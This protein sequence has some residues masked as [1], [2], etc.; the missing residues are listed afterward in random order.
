MNYSGF[1]SKI[2][3]S[4]MVNCFEKK[5]AGI[6]NKYDIKQLQGRI[7]EFLNREKDKNGLISLDEEYDYGGLLEYFNHNLMDDIIGWLA[8]PM[9]KQKDLEHDIISKATSYADANTPL[10]KKRIESIINTIARFIQGYY[11]DSIPLGERIWDNQTAKSIVNSITDF[12]KANTTKL[13]HEKAEKEYEFNLNVYIDTRREIIL[14]QPLF[15]WFYNSI[16]FRD[17]F[18][19]QLFVKP[20]FKGNIS[21]DDLIAYT[22]TYLVFLGHA[23]AGKS[24]LFMY[25]FAFSMI[26]ETYAVYLSAKEAVNNSELLVKI[27]QYPLLDR[28]KHLLL[29]DSVDEAFYN[30]Y[31]GYKQFIE[32][33]KML[34][35]CRVWLG[36]RTDFYIT[37]SSESTSLAQRIIELKPW[38]KD[39]YSAFINGYSRICQDV[40]LSQKIDH[41]LGTEKEQ[42]EIKK[43][44]FLLSLAVFLASENDIESLSGIYDLYER[45]LKQWIKKEHQRGSS[46]SDRATIMNSLLSAAKGIYTNNKWVFDDIALKNSAISC[47][48]R[49]HECDSSEMPIATSFYHRSLAA[50]IL[51]Q[52]IVECF[53]K[54]NWEELHLLLST[55]LKDDVTNFIGERF[56]CMTTKEKKE[57]SRIL[58]VMYYKYPESDDHLRY[59]EQL[60]YFITRIGVNVDRFLLGIISHNPQN[61]IMRLTLAYGCILSENESARQYALD[62]AKSISNDS[63]DAKTNRGWT[64]VYFGDVNDRDPYTYLDNEKR[65]WE[66]ARLA[67]IRRFTCK[68]PRLKDVRFWLFD[69]PLF[70]SFL[71]DRNWNDISKS[72]YDIIQSLCITGKF[73]N[74]Q[75]IAFL[76]K[77][78]A[79]ILKEYS[80]HLQF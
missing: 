33:L 19:K 66:K 20:L 46:M 13:A 72:E 31:E 53:V 8:A 23:G 63:M 60:I 71:K 34:E 6:K 12:L 45:F 5:F 21:F 62:Y 9:E 73:F 41:I 36:C 77:E 16:R 55:K 25:L 76:E 38:E 29:I 49:Y 30:D 58:S 79:E 70:H 51:A 3:E 59:H 10:S 27:N 17:A 50:F 74:T 32:K 48:L 26:Q 43:N 2:L 52:R 44:P 39:Q 56:R 47:L 18:S 61:L 80:Q 11:F 65:S 42:H 40:N 57:L 14:N 7:S 35:N 67:R 28:E 75:E 64:V 4:V 22:D 1:L 68:N 54:N 15:P 78:K 37:F 69:I 24:T